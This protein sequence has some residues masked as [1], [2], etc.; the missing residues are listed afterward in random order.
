MSVLGLSVQKETGGVTR[1]GGS[2]TQSGFL[3]GFHLFNHHYKRPN[4]TMKKK[5]TNMLSFDMALFT[6]SILN[7]VRKPW[8]HMRNM[9]YCSVLFEHTWPRL[10]HVINRHA[11]NDTKSR[12]VLWERR[13]DETNRKRFH[14]E[15]KHHGY[16]LH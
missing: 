3:K 8:R 15:H 4:C 5:M 13:S 11:K 1:M 12:N 7:H 14:F 16:S 2:N 10:Y 6:S 9:A